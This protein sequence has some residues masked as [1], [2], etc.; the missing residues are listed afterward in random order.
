MA[1]ERATRR[2]ALVGARGMLAH[3]VMDLVGTRFSVA[4]LEL[5]GF[6]VADRELVLT[7]L[8]ECSPDVIVNCAAYTD[9]DG[10]ETAAERA[11]R[12]NGDG[13]GFLAEAARRAGALLVHVSTDYVFDGTKGTA[14]VEEDALNPLSAYGRSKARGEQQITSSGLGRFFVVRTS[15]LYGPGG[16]NFVDTLLRVAAEREDVRVVADQVGSPTYTES[17]A[18]A[19]VA[20]IE[21]EAEGRAPAG[22]YHF[23]GEG[24]CSWFEF[25]CAI[26]SEARERGLD[27]RAADV[28]PIATRDYSA[29]A[30]RPAYAVLS[31]EKYRR[32]TGLEVPHWRE[33]LTRYFNARSAAG[34]G[35]RRRE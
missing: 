14:Y 7:R 8:R 35:A 6:D 21:L 13:P 1:A 5:P 10:C 24:S 16:T 25:A 18:E 11:N 15:W 26:V 19:L 30:A 29:A 32:V 28:M 3:A 33:A 27:L 9:V 20:L 12:V 2:L 34:S 22:I 17:L 4:P 31:K 23:S